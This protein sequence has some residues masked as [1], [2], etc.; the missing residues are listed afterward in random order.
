MIHLKMI[1]P[2]LGWGLKLEDIDQSKGFRGVFSYDINRPSLDNHIFLLYSR[3][4][5]AFSIDRDARLKSLPSFYSR[6]EVRIKGI[7][8]LCYTFVISNPNIRKIKDNCFGSLTDFEKMRIFKFWNF[9]DDDINNFML[10]PIDIDVKV[11]QFEQKVIPE[12]DYV[13]DDLFWE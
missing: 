12:W 4:T 9:T 7:T 11:E 3:K 8:F 5:T 1:I 10:H 2:L 13:P 6:R